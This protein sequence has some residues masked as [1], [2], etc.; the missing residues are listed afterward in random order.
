MDICQLCEFRIDNNSVKSWPITPERASD[1][2]L[3]AVVCK[4][5]FKFGFCKHFAEYSLDL[6]DSTGFIIYFF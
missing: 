4:T 3:D 5:T 6:G 1:A 2:P